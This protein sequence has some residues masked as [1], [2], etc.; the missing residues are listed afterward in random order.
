MTSATPT[1]ALLLALLAAPAAAMPPAP[2]AMTPP[3]PA[4][5][6]APVAAPTLAAERADARDAE[7][8]RL[9]YREEH[10]LRYADGVLAERL[11]TYRCADGTAFARKRVDYAGAPLA[12]AFVL[13][14]ARTGY[15]EGLAREGTQVRA[16][17]R[18]DAGAPER[19]GALPASAALVA[20]AGFDEFIR[21]RWD[22][23][24]PAGE[25]RIEFVVPS[26]LEALGVRVRGLGAADI[27]GVP[28]QRF[29]L[30][31]GGWLAW[32]APHIDVAYDARDRRLL[33]Y[34]GLSNIR[35]ADGAP[36]VARIDFAPPPPAPPASAWDAAAG[37]PL[38]ACRVGA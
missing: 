3:R 18:A 8:G 6:L 24:V 33:R 13:E 2:S 12:P 20:D 27:D 7:D 16:L 21:Q 14:D 5:N 35:D 4:A 1:R 32:V 30:T 11:V 25:A 23:L 28:A 34:E 17:V 10:L 36:L 37:E 15:R 38:A 29:R 9:L 22:A 31:L 19:S 26:R